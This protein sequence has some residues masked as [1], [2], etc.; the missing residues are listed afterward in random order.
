MKTI[1]SILI[2]TLFLFT[3]T[4]M[5]SAQEQDKEDY[6]DPT[7]LP[8]F[9]KIQEQAG[10]FEQLEAE[11][12]ILVKAYKYDE[13]ADI[14][15]RLLDIRP[16]TSSLWIML[17]HCYNGMNRWQDAYNAA[18]IAINLDPVYTYYRIERGIA[19]FRLGKNDQALADLRAYVGQIT[20]SAQGHFYLGLAQM[21]DRDYDG[22][23]A[24]L[25][26]AASFNPEMEV[27]AGLFLAQLDVLKGRKQE[28]LST[29]TDLSLVFKGMPM[30]KAI[31]DRMEDIRAQKYR[32]KT[33]PWTVY[34]SL[35]WFYDSNVI[36]ANDN[37]ALPTDISSRRSDGFALAL[38]GRYRLYSNRTTSL[39]GIL[40]YDGQVYTLLDDYDTM[41]ISPALRLDHRF[42]ERWSGRFRVQYRH[43]WLDGQ[44]YN[45]AFTFTPSC[46]YQWPV[47]RHFT[48]LGGR[49]KIADYD[50][51]STP[52]IDRDG[53]DYSLFIRHRFRFW[54]D[55]AQLGTGLSVGENDTD[56]TEYDAKYY[57]FNLNL[58]VPIGWKTTFVPR[59]SYT[60][61]DYNNISVFMTTP[62]KRKN[63][64]IEVGFSLTRPIT[65]WISLFFDINYTDNDSNI[66]D[67]EYDRTV[68]SL[69][70]NFRY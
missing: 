15:S 10:P 41:G 59:F 64:I 21:V 44:T 48:T 42:N 37:A 9:E 47:K 45:D 58:A 68:Y 19:A 23:E 1:A 6:L 35:K 25:K 8:G 3:Q 53:K 5:L 18:D 26:K 39:L 50:Q 69:G 56:G 31:Q 30:E 20:Q 17:A 24:S 55:R 54:N 34:G 40:D 27:V 4:P 57:R 46:T 28:A 61:Y 7:K 65:D 52:L 43:S 14:Y 12:Y 70:M 62:T 13:A 22:A 51:N 66:P 33:K 49:L 2:A 32:K 38:G 36:S 16:H 63:D 11:A 67:F 29:M 60:E